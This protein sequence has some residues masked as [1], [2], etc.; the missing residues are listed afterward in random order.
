MR[1]QDVVRAAARNNAAWCA[2]V[3]ETHAIHGRTDRHA[4][5]SPVRTPA[6]YPDAV[7]LAPGA[8]AAALLARIDTRSP[9]AS[10]KDSFADL[11]LSGP[12]PGAGAGAGGSNGDRVGDRH[13]DAFQVLFEASWIHR[14]SAPA[15]SFSAPGVSTQVVATQQVDWAPVHD[16]AT[17][18]AW[19]DAWDGGAGHAEVF[20][21]ELLTD[22]ATTVLAGRAGTGEVVGGAVATRSDG[23]VGLSNVFAGPGGAGSA[24]PG[25]LDV[26]AR[27]FPGVPAVGYESGDDLATALRHGFEVVGPLRV[28]VAAAATA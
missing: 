19:A 6:L 7:T 14:P 11:D 20:R 25:V 24:W 27:L 3:C 1:T 22:P 26:V 2:T 4:W 5:A 9:G 16:A 8:D 17:L 15:R 28:W 12:R 13:G 18:R 10:V 23:V 21:P